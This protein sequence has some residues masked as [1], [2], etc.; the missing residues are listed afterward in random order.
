VPRTAAQLFVSFR[1][2]VSWAHHV[3]SYDQPTFG[4]I[5]CP[6]RDELRRKSYIDTI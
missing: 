5:L 4:L 3:V 1:W 2:A 6:T